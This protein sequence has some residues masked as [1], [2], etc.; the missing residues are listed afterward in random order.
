MR[1]K[2]WSFDQL[3]QCNDQLRANFHVFCFFWSWADSIPYT[4]N[5]LNYH[6]IILY[7]RNYIYIA[8]I[9]KHSYNQTDSAIR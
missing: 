8:A 9:T 2:T 7:V 4:I 6:I 3:I 1:I 5:L